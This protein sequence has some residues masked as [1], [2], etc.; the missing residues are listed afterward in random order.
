MR[1]ES[2]PGVW[3]RAAHAEPLRDDATA[4][5]RPRL[6]SRRASGGDPAPSTHPFPGPQPPSSYPVC[7]LHFPGPSHTPTRATL[8][9]TSL[10][11]PQPLSRLQGLT[12][13]SQCATDLHPPKGR[14]AWTSPWPTHRRNCG[15]CGA[16]TPPR[17][18]GAGSPSSVLLVSEAPQKPSAAQRDLL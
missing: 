11:T 18:R 10:V 4:P 6:S 12:G 17:N 2:A 14:A 1:C 5:P 13:I 7:Q 9:N 8:A 3:A 15:G 16:A